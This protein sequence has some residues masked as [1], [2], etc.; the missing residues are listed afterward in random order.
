MF[1]APSTACVHCS[2]VSEMR[3][4][5]RPGGTAFNSSSEFQ[6]SLVYI[7][8]FQ[9]SQGY[10]EKPASKNQQTNKKLGKGTWR[11]G[12]ASAPVMRACCVVLCFVSLSYT[13]ES[14][15]SSRCSLRGQDKYVWRV[16]T[17]VILVT[18]TQK[19]QQGNHRMLLLEGHCCGVGF[20]FCKL[21]DYNRLH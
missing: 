9:D 15:H 7:E 5:A 1:S 19:I 14:Q 18:T 8:S 17:A 6:A 12:G 13:S 2:D 11:L 3:E 16:I 21:L 10:T 20:F 4:G